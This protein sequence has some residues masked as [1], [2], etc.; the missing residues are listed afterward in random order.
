[1]Q[2]LRPALNLLCTN[3]SFYQ[4]WNSEGLWRLMAFKGKEPKH[5]HLGNSGKLPPPL[6]LR[7]PGDSKFTCGGGGGG[8]G[9]RC[10][11]SKS[12]MSDFPGKT[13]GSSSGRGR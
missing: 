13:G 12:E 3:P 2:L 9:G 11:C 10:S 8:G 5:L 1:M 6:G 7:R 4:L